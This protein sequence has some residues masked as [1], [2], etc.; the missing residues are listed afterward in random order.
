[1]VYTI[2]YAVI[3]KSMNNSVVWVLTVSRTKKDLSVQVMFDDQ[4]VMRKS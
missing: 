3:F 4:S 2:Y 1:M